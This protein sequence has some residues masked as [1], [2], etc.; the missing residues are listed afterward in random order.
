MTDAEKEKRLDEWHEE[1]MA[2][3]VLEVEEATKRF[4]ARVA[5]SLG[6]LDDLAA[7]RRHKPGPEGMAKFTIAL[8]AWREIL[9]EAETHTKDL[10]QGLFDGKSLEEATEAANGGASSQGE[11]EHTIAEVYRTAQ[12]IE[13]AGTHKPC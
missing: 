9:S 10:L 2:A 3:A 11:I 13:L 5:K 12:M 1:F 4:Q 6:A 8:V 7:G